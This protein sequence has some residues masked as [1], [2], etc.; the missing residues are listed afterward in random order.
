MLL[1]SNETIDIQGL[2][3][4]WN[5]YNENDLQRVYMLNLLNSHPCVNGRS[6]QWSANRHHKMNFFKQRA[7]II[8]GLACLLTIAVLFFLEEKPS[9]D[10]ISPALPSSGDT[11]QV[12][13]PGKLGRADKEPALSMEV[14]VF[15]LLSAALIQPAG[16]LAYKSPKG[17]EWTVPFSSEDLANKLRELELENGGIFTYIAPSADAPKGITWSSALVEKSIW[18][19]GEGGLALGL[20]YFPTVSVNVI[21]VNG[22]PV[23]DAPVDFFLLPHLDFQKAQAEAQTNA[24]IARSPFPFQ[25]IENVLLG[26]ESITDIKFERQTG[27][28][29]EEGRVEAV[30]P[31]AGLLVL[32]IPDL[33]HRLFWHSVPVVP[34]ANGTLTCVLN[35]RP[36]AAGRV[37]YL[38]GT[39]APGIRVSLGTYLVPE[40][41]DFSSSDK[42]SGSAFSGVQKED[43]TVHRVARKSVITNHN[44]EYS[45]SI[46]FGI[47]YMAEVKTPNY[48]LSVIHPNGDLDDQGVLRQDFV[49]PSAT[50]SR[51]RGEDVVSLEIQDPSGK[52]L[53]NV[54]VGMA[55]Y[56]DEPWFR[57]YPKTNT[58]EIG[59]V[60]LPWVSV[61][62]S[63]VLVL[64][65]DSWQGIRS[66]IVE[67]DGTS[68]SVKVRHDN[69]STETPSEWQPGASQPQ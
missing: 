68:I 17:M 26:Y 62:D 43:G 64:M 16:E 11:K 14:S 35:P 29:G 37:T 58:G 33:D 57:M 65:H 48:Y 20:P 61:G 8:L 23:V 56:L 60:N 24:T 27:R 34:G 40:N 6:H 49:V 59:F 32:L 69:I 42:Q 55:P 47:E 5:I 22:E 9:S 19:E 63:V 51:D 44:G 10:S 18:M 31:A 7:T 38:D 12:P 53:K 21:D 15:D 52:V 2:R 45:T 3:G 41:V 25:Q 28:T 46:P 54:S 1:A 67:V 36:R 39:P 30:L 66:E 4:I 50:D 13:E